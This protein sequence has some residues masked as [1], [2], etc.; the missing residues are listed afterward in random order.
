M[1][2]PF[3]KS[4]LFNSEDSK[5]GSEI[6]RILDSPPFLLLEMVS[7]DLVSVNL[8]EV[9]RIDV[10]ASSGGVEITYEDDETEEFGDLTRESLESI[11]G[12]LKNTHKM[13]GVFRV[14]VK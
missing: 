8:N 13:L 10:I 9:R 1:E 2:Y 14:T 4:S 11:V 3:S 12:F 6:E 5:L 7:G